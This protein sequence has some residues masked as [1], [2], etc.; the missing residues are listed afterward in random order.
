MLTLAIFSHYSH[1]NGH[2]RLS[3][4]RSDHV[5]HVLGHASVFSVDTPVRSLGPFFDLG[6]LSFSTEL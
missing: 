6:C 4:C 5:S 1:P 2:D 3:H